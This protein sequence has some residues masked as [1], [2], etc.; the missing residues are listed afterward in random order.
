MV[1]LNI[2]LIT[3]LGWDAGLKKFI[4]KRAVVIY[5]AYCC[6]FYAVIRSTRKP[7]KIT[8]PNIS[9]ENLLSLNFGNSNFA[10]IGSD[11]GLIRYDGINVDIFHQTLFHQSHYL[12]QSLV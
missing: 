1:F 6:L 8:L 7:T 10:W 2:L 12:K 5:A 11:Q 3:I 9:T 4:N